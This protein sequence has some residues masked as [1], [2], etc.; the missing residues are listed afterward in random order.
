MENFCIIVLLLIAFCY[1]AYILIGI[2]ENLKLGG[3]LVK[4]WLNFGSSL[5][6]KKLWWINLISSKKKG[7]NRRT[8]WI[9]YNISHE[10]EIIAR[11][12]CVKSYKDKGIYQLR[13]D[14]KRNFFLEKTALK[15]ILTEKGWK[16]E[17]TDFWVKK[18]MSIFFHY[19]EGVV[20]VLTSNEEV[21]EELREKRMELSKNMINQLW[22]EA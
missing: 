18:N 21:L 17:D 1:V 5:L 7:E 16:E 19:N 11:F 9:N 12:I 6:G 20:Q 15:E 10:K 22:K 4:D 13:Y 14:I 2:V 8:Y 3:E